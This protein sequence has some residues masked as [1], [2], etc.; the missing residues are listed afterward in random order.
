[1]GLLDGLF[2]GGAG[3]GGLLDFLRNNAMNQQFG[4]GLQ[5]DQAQYGTPLGAMAQMP[6]SAPQAPPQ[7]Q[8]PSQPQMAQPALPQQQPQN[9]G[10]GFGDRLGSGLRGF[11]ANAPAGPLGSLIGGAAGLAGMGQGNIEGQ[12]ASMTAAY[13]RKAGVP[14][15]AIAAAVGN[16][17]VP[18]NPE[19]LKTILTKYANQEKVR[20]ATA[21]ERKAYGVPD[22]LPMSIDTT[23]NKPSYGPAATNVTTTINGEK[24]QDKVIGKG[25]GERFN[26]IQK[27]GM[28]APAAIGTLNLME[29][30]I[31][32]PNFYSGTGGQSATMLKRLAVSAGIAGAE[33]ATPNELFQKLSQK[34]VLDAASG[35]LGAGFSNA[36]RDYLNGTVANIDN[37]PE[38]N[39]RI[40]DIGRQVQQRNL[41]IAK[42]AREYAKK[43]NG[44][45]DSGFEDQIADYAEKNPLFA[46]APQ[47]TP[48]AG[49]LPPGWSVK[50]R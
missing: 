22:N 13:L 26:D 48:K 46:N 19:V 21:E 28:T 11:L 36:D 2:P 41:E 40:I 42:Q 16:G 34:S 8:I 35:S 17:R 12:K 32:D 50:A 49:G 10:M 37:T 39:K 7:P 5:S 31:S 18:G 45:L 4:S 38:G 27:A 9:A 25:Y 20:P 15:E 3:G 30:L 29:K 1:M 33:T 47:P 24:E 43:H 23:T 6:M 14:E 44:R